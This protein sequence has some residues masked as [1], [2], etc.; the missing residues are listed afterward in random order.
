MMNVITGE[1]KPK[2]LTPKQAR[3]FLQ[4]VDYQKLPKKVKK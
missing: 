4:H 1:V 2:G 3:E